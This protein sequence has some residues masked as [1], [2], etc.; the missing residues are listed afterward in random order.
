MR[1]NEAPDGGAGGGAVRGWFVLEDAR[2]DFLACSVV[3]V[4]RG[5]YVQGSRV[6][7]L[8]TLNCPR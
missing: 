3:V 1:L 8:E 5:S 7:S 2:K 4:P 6:E